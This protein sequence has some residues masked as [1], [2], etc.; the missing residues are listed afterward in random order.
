MYNDYIKQLNQEYSGR[1]LL[2]GRAGLWKYLDM[3]KIIRES[4]NLIENLAK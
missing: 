1:V 2:A 4:F 3:D